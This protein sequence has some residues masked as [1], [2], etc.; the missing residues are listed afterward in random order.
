MADPDSLFHAISRMVNV[1]KQHQAFGR[2]S[3]EWV[4]TDHPSLAVY[5]RTDRDEKILVIHN[6]SSSVQKIDLPAQY[7]YTYYDLIA[8][9]VI[10][11]GAGLALQ[12]YAYLWLKRK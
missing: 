1:R 9:S 11:V 10:Q 3:M 6:L 8:N 7:H 2:G 12:P 4:T 5:A